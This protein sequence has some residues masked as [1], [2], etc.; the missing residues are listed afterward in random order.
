MN[1]FLL[2]LAIATCTATVTFASTQYSGQDQYFAAEKTI[3]DELA[4]NAKKGRAV[5]ETLIDAEKKK[6]VIL[7]Q[8]KEQLKKLEAEKTNELS[9]IL[10]EEELADLNRLEM[11][12]R[13]ERLA[14]RKLINKH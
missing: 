13:D 2:M 7:R 10:T 3:F 4:L 11:S 9:K 12:I 8:A 14:K 6:R 1:K 5:R